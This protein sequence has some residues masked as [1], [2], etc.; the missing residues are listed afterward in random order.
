MMCIRLFMLVFDLDNMAP[1]LCETLLFAVRVCVCLEWK[2][3]TWN[4]GTLAYR[5]CK[6]RAS[7]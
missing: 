5:A 1:V 6:V 7:A 3:V 4:G 2:H